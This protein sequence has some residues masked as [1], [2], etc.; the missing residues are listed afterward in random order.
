MA[1][2]N[3]GDV[4]RE[5]MQRLDVYKSLLTK[6]NPKINL[7]SRS[8]LA[9]MDTRHFQDSAQILDLSDSSATNWV[10]MGSG[11]GFPGLVIALLAPELRPELNMTLIESDQRKCSFLRTVARESGGR[12]CSDVPYRSH[13]TAERGHFVCARFG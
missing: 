4:S 7:V 12:T 8:T 13:A 2:L 1:R 10:D 5:T 6:W 3:L 9:E 11:G